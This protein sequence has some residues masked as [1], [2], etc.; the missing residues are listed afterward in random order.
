[1]YI[2]YKVLTTT[3]TYAGILQRLSFES[4]YKG[5]CKRV[6]V[7]CF[8]VLLFADVELTLR[9][10]KHRP[11]SKATARQLLIT[12]NKDAPK[13]VVAENGYFTFN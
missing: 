13:L 4:R 3:R 9:P 8:T 5:K 11:Y 2:N 12:V 7:D 1:M 10:A 6:R